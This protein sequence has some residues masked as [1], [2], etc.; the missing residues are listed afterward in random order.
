MISSNG[1]NKFGLDFY[2]AFIK[3]MQIYQNGGVRIN[4]NPLLLEPDTSGNYV[5]DGLVWG[6]G[7]LAGSIVNGAPAPFLAGY[8]GDRWVPLIQMFSP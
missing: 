4:G 2:T 3:R 7:G 6:N 8:W 5:N 1:T